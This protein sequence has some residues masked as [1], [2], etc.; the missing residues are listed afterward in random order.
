MVNELRRCTKCVMPDTRPGSVFDE[1]GVCLACRNYEKRSQ[2]D[3]VDRYRQLGNLCDQYR[4]LDG[5]YDCVIAVSGGKD[6]HFMLHTLKRELGMNPL[7]ITIT[8]PFTK[9]NAGRLNLANLIEVFGCDHIAYTIS[10][11]FFKRITRMDFEEHGEPLRFVEIAIYIAPT[12]MA[13]RLGIPLIFYGENP[14]YD[15]G[16]T[17]EESPLIYPHLQGMMVKLDRESLLKRGVSKEEINSVNMPGI[18]VDPRYL[19]YYVPWE[20]TKHL[21]IAR[22]YGFR[23]VVGEWDRVGCSENF[24]Q[25]DSVGYL[26]HIWMK[27]PKFGFQRISDVESRRIRAGLQTREKAME[28]VEARDSTL[29][30]KVYEDFT[31]ILGYTEQEFWAIVD[32]WNKYYDRLK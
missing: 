18:N 21:E 15:Y 13:E 14:A 31:S 3:W 9:T 1:E 7:L 28:I 5:S 4:R 22:K 32:K 6:S 11:E 26:M 27:Y 24:E 29:D 23:D 10:T 17:D 12:R 25:I 19:G 2:V 16:T 8:D 30:Y 20:S